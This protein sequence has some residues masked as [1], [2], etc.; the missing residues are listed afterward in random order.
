MATLKPTLFSFAIF[1][2]THN[3]H[4]PVSR[5]NT[6]THPLLWAVLRLVAYFYTFSSPCKSN[7]FSELSLVKR[8][9]IMIWI[10]ADL[11][12]WHGLL[13]SNNLIHYTIFISVSF[14]KGSWNLCCSKIIKYNTIN[15]SMF[16]F[17]KAVYND[18]NSFCLCFIFLKH[19][20]RLPLWWNV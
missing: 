3:T 19:F 2:P 1:Q 14:K 17:Y 12:Q 13:N 8:Q 20:L 16:T 10:K 9:P 7:Q 6:P 5:T 11:P 18:Y 4:R 15:E